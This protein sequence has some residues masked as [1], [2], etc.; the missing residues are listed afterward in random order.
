VNDN[1]LDLDQIDKESLIDDVSDEALE[2]AG[3]GELP[4]ALPC[5]FAPFLAP[6]FGTT[7]C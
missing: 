1:S 5:T 2:A 6:T 7:P 3:M 4:R